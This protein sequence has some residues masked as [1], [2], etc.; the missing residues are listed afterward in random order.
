MRL[1]NGTC[2][3]EET[4]YIARHNTDINNQVSVVN[5]E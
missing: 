4:F 5:L 1:S 2:L 3:K